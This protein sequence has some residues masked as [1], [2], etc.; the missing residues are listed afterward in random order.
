[1]LEIGT[2][3]LMSGEWKRAGR[4]S[5]ARYRA[6]PRLYPIPG[7]SQEIQR[8]TSFNPKPTGPHAP[9]NPAGIPGAQP[10]EGR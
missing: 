7:N 5:V 10:Q 8:D 3:G 6:S 4:L 1:M 9:P 2:S